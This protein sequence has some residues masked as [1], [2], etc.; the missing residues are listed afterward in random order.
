MQNAS[1]GGGGVGYV[2]FM[3][4]DTTIARSSPIIIGQYTSLDAVYAGHSGIYNE[5]NIITKRSDNTLYYFGLNTRGQHGDGTQNA[6][7][8][9]VQLSYDSSAVD[10]FVGGTNIIV[11]K[12]Y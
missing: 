11:K 10:V 8:S 9:P 2:R 5:V 12:T 4:S 1:S 6:R 3:P 7:S